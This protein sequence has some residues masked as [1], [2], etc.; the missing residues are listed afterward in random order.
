MAIILVFL[1][2]L[3]SGIVAI[4]GSR[5]KKKD[6][7]VE[8]IDAILPQTQCGKCHYTGC[9]PY[10]RNILYGM[11]NIDQCPPGG[12]STIY[13]LSHLLGRQSQNMQHDTEA[14]VATID[15]AAC[16]GCVKC[17][18]ACPVDAIIGAP[19][20]MHTVLSN[21]CTGCELCVA[22]C[23]TN[24]ITMQPTEL[25]NQTPRMVSL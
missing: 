3:I 6:Y 23:P 2:G 12:S 1:L 11:A 10:A 14:L 15:E 22:P 5:S 7:S 24:C 25:K 16:I 4:H 13:Q 9:K 19:K 20:V 21:D 8:S 17:I 18:T